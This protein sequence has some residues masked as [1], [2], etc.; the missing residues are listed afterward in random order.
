MMRTTVFPSGI[1]VSTLPEPIDYAEAASRAGEGRFFLLVRHGERPPIDPDD[2]TFGASLPLTPEGEALA[3]ACGRAL[4]PAASR[5][6]A[7]RASPYRRTIL[8]AGFVA[9]EMGFGAA[10]VEPCDEVGIPGLWI[11]D[12]AAVHDGQVRDTAWAY[13][14]RLAREGVAEGYRPS[15]ESADMLFS[16]LSRTDFGAPNACFCTHDCHLACLYHALGIGGISGNNWIRFLQGCA[17]FETAPSAFTAACLLP[18]KSA[19]ASPYAK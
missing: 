2:P 3:R 18:D 8:T 13:N 5:P 7:F 16:W 15:V 11:S 14:D 4:R 12:A 1:A 19:P 9:E 17:L 6:W 10:S